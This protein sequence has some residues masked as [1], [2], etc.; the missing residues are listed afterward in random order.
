MFGLLGKLLI[1]HWASSKRA[2]TYPSL[3]PVGNLKLPI[4]PLLVLR[5]RILSE[6]EGKILKQCDLRPEISNSSPEEPGYY[7]APTLP[8]APATHP[9]ASCSLIKAVRTEVPDTLNIPVPV[10]IGSNLLTWLTRGIHMGVGAAPVGKSS[11][12]FDASW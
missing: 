8:A 4:H 2:R 10:H 5:G 11:T 12:G 7:V 1:F 3:T 9:R 6:H